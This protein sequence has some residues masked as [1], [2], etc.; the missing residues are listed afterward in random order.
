[1]I[2]IY[3][4]CHEAFFEI[5]WVNNYRNIKKGLRFIRNAT[6][7]IEINRDERGGENMYKQFEYAKPTYPMT[8]NM[9]SHS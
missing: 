7:I 6:I 1:M 5:K 3:K 8:D 9:V 2:N 4:D